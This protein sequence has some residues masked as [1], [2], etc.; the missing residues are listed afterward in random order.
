MRNRPISRSEVYKSAARFIAYR[1]GRGWLAPFTAQDHAAFEA[2]CSLVECFSFGG[3]VGATL[4]MRAVLLAM[5]ASVRHFAYLAIVAIGDWHMVPA[6]LPRI[7]PD[8]DAESV[9]RLRRVLEQ[10]GELEKLVP[11]SP[12]RRMGTIAL[13]LELWPGAALV[14]PRELFRFEHHDLK[15]KGWDTFEAFR[16]LY[17]LQDLARGS[18][19]E[20]AHDVPDGAAAGSGKAVSR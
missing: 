9:A 10:S 13:R 2:F 11:D 14:E 18:G 5:Q 17:A 1:C 15:E 6:L 3:G 12:P 4:A 7:V 19:L 20:P 8:G 16:W